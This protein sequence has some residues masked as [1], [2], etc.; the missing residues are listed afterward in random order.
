MSDEQLESSLHDVAPMASMGSAQDKENADP[1]VWQF[2]PLTTLENVR[3]WQSRAVGPGLSE[4][5]PTAHAGD[6]GGDAPVDDDSVPS[7]HGGS[8]RQSDHSPCP[9]PAAAASLG[10]RARTLQV[11]NYP[12]N[13]HPIAGATVRGSSHALFDC[14]AAGVARTDEPSPVASSFLPADFQ[15][16][17]LW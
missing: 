2:Y 17:F 16:E 7:Q 12:A 15:K 8:S 3:A 5:P 14:G 13:S 9:I 1:D 10:G 6:P 11:D 4:I